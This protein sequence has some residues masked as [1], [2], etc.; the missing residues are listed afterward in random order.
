MRA[1]AAL[2]CMFLAG[3][4]GAETVPVGV[5]LCLRQVEYSKDEE[6]RAAEDLAKLPPGSEVAKMMADYG[7][8]RRQNKACSGG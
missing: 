1:A 2:A 3:C 5:P 4:V 6:A 8:M 7:E